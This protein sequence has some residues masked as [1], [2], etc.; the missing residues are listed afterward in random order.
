MKLSAEGGILRYTREVRIRRKW[1][2]RN[3]WW[4]RQ[5]KG[6]PCPWKMRDYVRWGWAQKTYRNTCCGL[7]IKG[8]HLVLQ[9]KACVCSASQMMP[10][11]QSQNFKEVKRRKEG[12]K[13]GGKEG[14]R[15]GREGDKL[16]SQEETIQ[17]S[18]RLPLPI[19]SLN[20]SALSV[21]SKQV[22]KLVFFISW[23]LRNSQ[24]RLSTG[25]PFPAL[26]NHQP[27]LYR[28][29]RQ[30]WILSF[31]PPV[32]MAVPSGGIN[33]HFYGIW[34]SKVSSQCMST[35]LNGQKQEEHKKLPQD[36]WRAVSTVVSTLWPM[37]SSSQ[38]PVHAE[39]V[40]V[41]DAAGK[42]NNITC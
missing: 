23:L 11:F 8:S 15:E 26:R 30:H 4:A 34:E 1:K 27:H 6:G 17:G 32:N 37:L 40:L 16:P 9:S 3:K 28:K 5:W 42:K 36:L 21:L 24:E 2:R 10:S 22:L 39:R 14:R 7:F 12:R 31:L 33:V 20:C 13:E 41:A 35:I 38:C 19:F 29:S 18:T 25:A